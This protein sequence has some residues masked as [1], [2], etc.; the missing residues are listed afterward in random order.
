MFLSREIQTDKEIWGE[1]A[2]KFKPERFLE[3]SIEK[4]HPYAYFPF[5]N[6]PRICPGHKYAQIVMKVFLSKFLLK[7]RVKS[8]LSYEDLVFQMR[9]SLKIKQGFEMKVER[10]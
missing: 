7:Y 5:S 9:I 4:I 1:D 6:G 3:E 8:E 10:R 2:E